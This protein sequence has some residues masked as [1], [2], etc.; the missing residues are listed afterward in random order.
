MS[1][2]QTWEGGFAQH[3]GLEAQGGTTY[4]AIT[5]LA[6]LY[7]SAGQEVWRTR[8]DSV[9]ATRYLASR[10]LG[11]N[12]KEADDST[13][14]VDATVGGGFQGRPGKDEDVCYSFWCGAAMRVRPGFPVFGC[15]LAFPSS[16]EADIYI[17]F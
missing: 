11:G 2:T 10:Q 1:T 7:G 5:S 9:G 3:P 6:L 17:M 16:V 14:E 4:C 8:I 12:T 15:T 13:S